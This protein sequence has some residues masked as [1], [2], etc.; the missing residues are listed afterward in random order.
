MSADLVGAEVVVREAPDPG[1]G[2][3]GRTPSE[4]DIEM[5]GERGVITACPLAGDIVEVRFRDG[6]IAGFRLHQ[7]EIVGPAP[8]PAGTRG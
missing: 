4:S 5:L 6:R 1:P 2:S 3:D 7:L 8:G